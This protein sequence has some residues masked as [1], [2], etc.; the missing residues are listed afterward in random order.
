VGGAS[1]Q[2]VDL[3]YVDHSS[4][5][6]RTRYYDFFSQLNAAGKNSNDNSSNNDNK[7]NRSKH[8]FV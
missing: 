1:E 5:L 3:G 4:R 8:F 7:L 6:V 2:W